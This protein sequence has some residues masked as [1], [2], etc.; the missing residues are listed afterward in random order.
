MK[1]NRVKRTITIALHFVLLLL[2]TACPPTRSGIYH[3]VKKGETL[4]SISRTYD[5]DIQVIAEYNDIYNPDLIYEDQ[6]LFIPG[7]SKIEDVDVPDT[8]GRAGDIIIS[9]GMFIWPTDG[10]V[11]SLFG[12]RWGRMHKGLD[13]DNKTGT[14]IHA[15]MDGRVIFAGWKGGYGNVVIIEHADNYETRY[16]HMSKI[17]VKVGYVVR[18]GDVIG[19]M[20][21]TGNSTGPH[22]HF[23]IRKDG[24]ARNPLFY[25][26]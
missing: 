7:V 19:L 1:R 16:A 25:L 14:P 2:F 10:L 15:S 6:E 5:V 4:Y 12:I 13:I 17:K 24:E 20:G 22:V 8:N 18:Q 11:Y 21:S 9:S 26:P 3:I 23:E